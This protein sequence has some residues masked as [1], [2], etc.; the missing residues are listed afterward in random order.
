MGGG[1]YVAGL[2]VTASREYLAH[3]EQLKMLIDE[4]KIATRSE[5]K[6][7]LAFLAGMGQ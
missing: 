6:E 7:L 5:A 2:S 3:V 1:K 4:K